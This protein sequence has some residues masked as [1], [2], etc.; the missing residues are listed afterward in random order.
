MARYRAPA[1]DL[2]PLAGA[3]STTYG[4]GRL[5]EAPVRIARGQQ[6]VVWSL[7][8]TGGRFAVKQ[9]LVAPDPAGAAR[10][11]AFVES[12]LARTAVLAPRPVRTGDGEVLT[13][14]AGVA[15]RVSE[16]VD[17]VPS[18]DLDPGV[19]GALVADLHREPLP[20]PERVDP[21]Y[22]DPVPEREWAA[23][24]EA[25]ARAG[26]P[27][28]AEF[29]E[30]AAAHVRLQRRLVPAGATRLCHR[31]LWLDNL[32]S[33]PDGRICVIDWDNCGPADPGQELAMPLWEQCAGD[34]VRAR[35]LLDAYRDHGGPGVM[36][37]P[38]SFTMVIAQ[39]GHFAATAGQRWLSAADE[40]DR[41]RMEAW[42]RE[43]YDQ[44]LD[45]AEIALLLGAATA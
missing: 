22:T 37:G 35:R 38:G 33:T 14:V 5:R 11:A 20:A 31:D 13:E 29:A 9:V 12:V 7:R 27:F 24:G 23:T 25:L 17:L 39:L 30:F 45:E 42:F 41:A 40:E 19:V 2:V 26:A 10:D 44:P 18:V 1:A 32:P 16:W 28:A 8:T 43:G 6:G 34:P 3:I 15:V 21:W 4:L 36:D